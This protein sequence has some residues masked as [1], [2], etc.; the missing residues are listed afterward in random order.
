MCAVIVTPNLIGD[1]IDRTSI[2][3]LFLNESLCM[4]GALALSEILI[5]VL[6][7]IVWRMKV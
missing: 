4:S 2:Y 7:G 5:A 6:A 1:S 3:E